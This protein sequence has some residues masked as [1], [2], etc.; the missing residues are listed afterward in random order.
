ME[1]KMGKPHFTDVFITPHAYQRFFER[2]DNTITKDEAKE[3]MTEIAIMGKVVHVKRGR[4]GQKQY[5]L[6]YQRLEILIAVEK[7]VAKVVTCYGDTAFAK[8]YRRQQHFAQRTYC[9]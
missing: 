2:V 8:W 6:L 4:Y 9:A 1:N 5:V 7:G 3:M